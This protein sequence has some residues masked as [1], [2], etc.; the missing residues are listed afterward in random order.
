MVD[1]VVI[2][3]VAFGFLVGLI[4][5]IFL[6]KDES[7]MHWLKHGVHAIPVMIIFTF[8]AFNI[9]WALSLFKVHDN[10]TIDIIARVVIGLV[11]M[12]KVKAAASITGR[13]GVGESWTHV[14]IIGILMMAG[15]FIWEYVLRSQI[16]AMLP[17][18]K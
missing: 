2:P 12:A 5:L 6:A 3:A 1:F 10:M 16:Q 7:G 13:G 17:W 14:L 18:I 15:P 11:A 9:S 4:E 8:I